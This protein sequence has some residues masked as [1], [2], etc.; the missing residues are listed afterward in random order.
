MS[1]TD[2][3]TDSGASDSG[4]D[5]SQSGGDSNSAGGSTMADQGGSE[6]NSASG[7][8]G[9]GSSPMTDAST[10]DDTSGGQASGG[11]GGTQGTTNN[12]TTTTTTTE[13][14]PVDCGQIDNLEECESEPMC[15]PA[16]AEKYNLTPSKVCKADDPQFVACM[17]VDECGPP[18]EDAFY[19]FGDLNHP[20]FDFQD[21]CLPENYSECPIE[22]QDSYPSCD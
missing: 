19:C 6:S 11:T 18:N 10:T 13:P 4:T 2:S 12:T 22:Q 5:S 3:A 17:P 21:T 20:W 15:A 14:D 7:G 1:E 9:G 8:S 16:I